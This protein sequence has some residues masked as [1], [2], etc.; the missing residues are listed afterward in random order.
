MV[1]NSNIIAIL[2]LVVM[3][4]VML[5]SSLGDSAIFD[6]VAHIP[7]GYTS[8][9][10]KDGRI[11]PEH[12][13]LLKDLAA[14]PLLFLNLHFDKNQPFWTQQDVNERQWDAGN[15]LLYGAGPPRL[16]PR[17]DQVGAGGE[18][19]NNP[20]QILFWARLP[21]IIL[22]II[23]GWM[24]FLWVR[25]LYGDEAGLITLFLYATSPTILAHSR[26]VTTDVGAAFGFFLG[27][28]FFLKFLERRDW[29]SLIITGIVFGIIN[30][31]K[32]SMPLLVPVYL[33]LGILWVYLEK[34]SYLKFIR[35]LILIGVIGLAVIFTVYIWQVWNYPQAQEVADVKYILAGYKMP[36]LAQADMWL[37]EHQITRPLGHYVFGFLMVARRTAG[38]NTAYFEGEVSS[39]GWLR[40]FPTLL[41]VK[42][43]LG[44]FI[45]AIAAL[46][47]MLLKI[48]RDSFKK[49]RIKNWMRDNIAI[50]AAIVFIIIYWAASMANPLNIGVRHILPT[51][52]FFYFLIAV[53]ISKWPRNL[54]KYVFLSAV[55]IWMVLEMAFAYPYF[56]SYYNKLGGGLQNGY[57]I[58]TDSN[59]DW[60]QDLK[61]LR[62]WV[63]QNNVPKIYLDY[64]G[65]GS[66]Q[67]YLGDKFI[68][69]WSARGIPPLA[70]T[71]A[72][73]PTYFAVSLNSLAGN[74]ANP[75]G[76][77]KIKSE[78]TYSWL[79]N[80]TPVS[81]GG[82]SILIYKF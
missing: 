12:P 25:K 37:V 34:T 30:L 1:K 9:V 62:D 22:S 51:L 67:Y 66:P 47:F 53:G 69:W 52:P 4:S 28:V 55:G 8:L 29:K 18:A 35:Q 17:S 2:M 19:G 73:E 3:F 82:S 48:K 60:G 61:R 20:D 46:I 56:L 78:D 24:L 38:G 32:F 27:I 42:E 21:L 81:R 54:F 71:E 5:F 50:V 64:F 16:S 15:Y 43:Q 75:I 10:F 14:F 77:I 13:P 59:Y 65:G 36:I 76:D 74:Q 79:K 44:L 63:N 6:E 41:L 58:A 49:E 26:F 33:I 80:K 68:P 31:F 57:K 23:F 11:N 70:P 72:S 45:L 40:Y 7:A 39:K